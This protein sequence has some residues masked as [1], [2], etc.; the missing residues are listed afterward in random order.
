MALLVGAFGIA[1]LVICIVR[2]GGWL[3]RIVFFG[4]LLAWLAGCPK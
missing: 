3:E 2:A 4:L 1:V